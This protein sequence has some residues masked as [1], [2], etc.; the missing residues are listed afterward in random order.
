[1]IDH[2]KVDRFIEDAMN[3][4]RMIDARLEQ[5]KR[6]CAG[7]SGDKASPEAEQQARAML[8]EAKARARAAGQNS[9][10][11]IDISKEERPAAAVSF[12]SRSRRRNLV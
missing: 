9:V 1:M 8:E 5:V 11:N 2:E 4:M 6:M 10:R 7:Y 3:E 12:A